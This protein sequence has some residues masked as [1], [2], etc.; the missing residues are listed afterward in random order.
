MQSAP[1]TSHLPEDIARLARL[2][3]SQFRIPG[4]GIRFGVDALIGFVPGIGD[5]L[6][7]GLGL[8]IVKRAREEGASGFVIARM[9]WNLLVDTVIGAIPLVGDLFDI[10][11]KANM[12]NV[13][14]LQ[15]HLE[16]RHGKT[17]DQSA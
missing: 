5:L 11:F 7:G 8:Y 1:D 2:L 13:K 17:I 6:S 3:D 16:K 4:T 9:L 12:K 15:K 14:L 10:E